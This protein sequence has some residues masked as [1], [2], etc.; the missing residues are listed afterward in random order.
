LSLV[1]YLKRLEGLK[2]GKYEAS[3]KARELEKLYK[4]EEIHHLLPGL[5]E[6]ASQR[7]II[8]LVDELDRG[9]DSSED[10]Q[11][12][13][14]GLFQACLSVNSLHDN[15]RVYISLRQ[16]LYDDV[17]ALYEDAQKYRDLIENIH[18]S[19]ASLLKLMANRIRHSLPALADRDDQDC[20]NYLFA[21][22]PGQA[23][24]RSFGYMIER[25]LYR[26][27]EIIQFSTQVIEC[28]QYGSTGPPWPYGTITEAE[29]LY[30]ADRVRDIAAEYRFQWPGLLSVIEAFRGQPQV[31]ARDDLELL[32]LGLITREIPSAGTGGWLDESSPDGLI[33]ILWQVGLL[34]A[35]A[36]PGRDSAA[37]ADPAAPASAPFLGPHQA[38]QLSLATAQRFQVHPMFRAYLGTS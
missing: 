26:P 15:L 4:L 33:E 11:A 10:A 24:A 37:H 25:T 1:S 13:L 38:R 18:W 17:P 14:A 27:R 7:R 35:G 12:F 20:W 28:A 6:I 32:A 3:V 16:E 36:D 22:P 19:E 23:R 9:W 29:S 21:A 8:V 30:S 2:I 31:I 5:Q 34:L